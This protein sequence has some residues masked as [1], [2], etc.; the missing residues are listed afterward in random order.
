MRGYIFTGRMLDTW[1]VTRHTVEAFPDCYE[2]RCHEVARAVSQ[3]WEKRGL[4]S[5]C[6]IQVVDGHYGAVDHS[7]LAFWD[8]GRS[9]IIDP[10]AVGRLPMV[11]LVDPY[12]PGALP[13]YRPQDGY[14]SDIRPHE[15]AALVAIGWRALERMAIGYPI[16]RL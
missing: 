10:Y 15:V 11:Q 9:C 1:V 14:R 4:P 6:E 7:W 13:M 2:W 3:I 12:V 8:G 16:P 5:A